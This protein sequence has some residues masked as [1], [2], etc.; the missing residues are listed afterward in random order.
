MA[1]RYRHRQFGTTLVALL[2]GTVIGVLVAAHHSGWHPLAVAVLAIPA[3]VLLLFH[4]L[5]VEVTDDTVHVYFGAGLAAFDF[6]LR[7]IESV[8]VVRNPWYYGWGIRITPHGWLYNVSGLDAVELT[9]AC[10]KRVRIGTDEPHRL[11]Q[12][13]E[14]ARRAAAGRPA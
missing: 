2:G 14:R 8:A 6:A 5:T 1:M 11:A 13:I 12:A 4:S 3:L 7:D 10:G 9:L